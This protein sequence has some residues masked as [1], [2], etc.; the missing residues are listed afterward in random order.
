[1]IFRFLVRLIAAQL[2]DVITEVIFIIKP[3]H[4]GRVCEEADININLEQQHSLPTCSLSIYPSA[5]KL[6]MAWICNVPARLIIQVCPPMEEARL[7]LLT[8]TYS[9]NVWQFPHIHLGLICSFFLPVCN[10]SE[11]LTINK[12]QYPVEHKEK[13]RIIWLRI[14]WFFPIKGMSS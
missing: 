14:T 10:Y 4:A 2:S 11:I 1:M 8:V 5:N 12:K 6:K 7:S 9:F 3:L 13:Q